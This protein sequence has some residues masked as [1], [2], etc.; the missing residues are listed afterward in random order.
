ML[1][2]A[3]WHAFHVFGGVPGRSIYDNMKTAAD[4]IPS[5]KVCQVNARFL[6]MTGHC[7]FAPEF[8]NPAA[9][10]KKGQ[11]EKNVQDSRHLILHLMPDF[12]DPADLNS[13][14]EQ[15]CLEQ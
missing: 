11:V 9:G 7:V 4:R 14:L 8:C 3:H 6:A 2:D 1:F 12:A 13:R 15:R 5:G 10:W